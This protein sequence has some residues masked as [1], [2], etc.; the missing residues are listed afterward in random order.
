MADRTAPP[1]P[2]DPRAQLVRSEERLRTD[3]HRVP[4]ARVRLEKFIVTETRT[5]TVEVRREEVRLVHLDATGPAGTADTV[6]A[7]PGQGVDRWLTL[8]EE[9][10]AI[11]TEIV[12]IERVRLQIDTVTGE[13][14]VTAEVR[15]EQFAFETVDPSTGDILSTGAPTER[16]Q[17]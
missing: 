14:D 7:G 12:P 9:R 6:A 5:V 4:Y 13:R 8:S 10:V 3:V 2:D 17:A 16:G 1:D 11:T 15:V